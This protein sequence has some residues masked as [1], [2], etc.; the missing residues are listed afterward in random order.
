MRVAI[1]VNGPTYTSQSL[2]LSAQLTRNLYPEINSEARSV[3]AMHGTPGTTLKTATNGL[4]NRGGGIHNGELY[5]VCGTDLYKIDSSFS[6]TVIGTVIGSGQCKLSSDG[7]NLLIATGSTPYLYNGSTLSTHPSANAGTPNSFSYLNQ[8]FWLDADG[9]GILLTDLN[10]PTTIQNTQSLPDATEETLPD[11]LLLIH[12]FKKTQYLFGTDSITQWYNP[13]VGTPPIRPVSNNVLEMG[14]GA[15][16][17]VCGNKRFV[18]FLDNELN[19][20][21]LNGLI[22]TPIGNPALGDQWREYSKWDDAIGN[23]WSWGH[24]HFYSLSFPTANK[25]WVYHEKSGS[26]FEMAYGVAGA[27][28]V[29]NSYHWI[30]NKHVVIDYRNSNILEWDFETFTD[31]GDVIQRQRDTAVVHGGL[32]DP[33]LHGREIF[34]SEFELVM[35]TGI[36]V[37]S[38]QGSA[39]RVM[40]SYSDDGGRSFGQEIWGDMGFMGNYIKLTWTNLGSFQSRIFRIRLSDPVK[41]SIISAHAEIEAGL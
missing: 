15:V 39:P 19:P 7:T 27:R 14:L 38:G 41:C 31:N 11:D 12:R 5:T 3:T 33:S 10:D 13:G 8:R 37:I 24:E 36:G 17:S 35:E 29:L 23:C 1:P 4:Q 6:A 32:F 16:R 34:M 9:G 40:L 20:Q 25:T 2:P 21:Q 22:N 30:Y 26:W 18:Y 28:H